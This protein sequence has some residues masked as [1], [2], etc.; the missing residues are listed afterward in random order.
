[1]KI[2][3]TQAYSLLPLK[4]YY[5]CKC[6]QEETEKQYC[7]QFSFTLN[8]KVGHHHSH[9]YPECHSNCTKNNSNHQQ[10][11]PARILPFCRCVG[12]LLTCHAAVT[13]F[14]LKCII[15]FNAQCINFIQKDF[16]CCPM[17]PR[18]IVE[19]LGWSRPCILI[20]LI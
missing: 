5:S 11:K 7:G 3:N 15:I 16:V 10:S 19:L 2:P 4:N 9:H 14:H 8:W 20:Q 17:C 12:G 6:R 18:T 1:M 13:E